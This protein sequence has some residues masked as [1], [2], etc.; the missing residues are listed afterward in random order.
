MTYNISSL[1]L[2]NGTET[3][4]FGTSKHVIYYNPALGLKY[5]S[6]YTLRAAPSEGKLI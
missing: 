2:T 3:H 6:K 1:T 4:I 5:V